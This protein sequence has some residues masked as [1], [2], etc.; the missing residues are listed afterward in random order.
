MTYTAN[1]LSPLVDRLVEACLPHLTLVI[2]LSVAPLI[3]NGNVICTLEAA[4]GDKAKTER[5]QEIA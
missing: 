5:G 3:Q 4:R 1:L 2:D